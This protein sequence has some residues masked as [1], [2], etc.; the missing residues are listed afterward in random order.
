MYKII[1]CYVLRSSVMTAKYFCMQKSRY[2]LNESIECR[3]L[4]IKLRTLNCSNSPSSSVRKKILIFCWWLTFIPVF[5]VFCVYKHRHGRVST[6]L[7]AVFVITW[8]D[9]KMQRKYWKHNRGTEFDPQTFCLF[10]SLEFVSE[11]M[12][13]KNYQIR[14]CY[15]QVLTS[16][17][18]TGDQI[19]SSGDQVI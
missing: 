12:W 16:V 4:R 13:K 11:L 8:A 17:V 2:F 3:T 9:S 19:F 6:F 1:Y 5:V 18:A 7:K 15:E 14:V 10:K